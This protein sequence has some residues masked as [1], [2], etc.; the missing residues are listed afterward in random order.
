MTDYTSILDDKISAIDAT[1]LELSA[2]S[3]EQ[4][5]EI[6]SQ[7]KALSSYDAN[8]QK[9]LADISARFDSLFS[10]FETLSK[11]LVAV[12]D[13][14][15]KLNSV[16]FPPPTEAEI[17]AALVPGT[18]EP[19]A[20]NTGAYGELT[21]RV[22]NLTT[23]KAGEVFEGLLIEGQVTIKH[24]VKFIRCHI[25]GNKP[26]AKGYAV[27][28]SYDAL[29]EQAELIDCTIEAFPHEWSAASVQGRDIKLTRC[30]IFGGVDGVMGTNSKV[31]VSASYIHDLFWS[32]TGHTDGGPTHNDLIQVEGGSGH[33]VY[34]NSFVC[35]S[36]YNSA[37]MVTQNVG[38]ITGLAIEKNTF[39]SVEPL[40][41]N[42]T[43]VALN[44]YQSKKGGMTGVVL[45]NNTFSGPATWKQARVA[46]IDA[47]T[48]DPLLTTGDFVT[49]LYEDG[50]PA[51]FSRSNVTA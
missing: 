26:T 48:Y 7:S 31:S 50:T 4:A 45:R 47:Q 19:D 2:R 44:F 25:K 21:K 15:E 28:R 20:T 12:S 14:I 32:P 23:T 38:L 18:Y 3:S 27:V 34:G 41:E 10:A 37:I 40:S 36:K 11:S 35:G 17:R 8:V 39:R 42:Q 16:I 51:K 43:P 24:P 22:G 1:L 6:L 5:A 29:P 9:Q 33:V 13:A 30:N 46:W 49:N